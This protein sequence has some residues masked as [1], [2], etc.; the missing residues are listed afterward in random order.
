MIHLPTAW[1]AHYI[2]DLAATGDSNQAGNTAGRPDFE[3]GVN[4]TGTER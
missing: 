4:R 1:W 3:P 2:G